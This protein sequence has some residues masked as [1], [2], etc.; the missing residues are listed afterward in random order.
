MNT[1]EHTLKVKDD[2][3]PMQFALYNI[4]IKNPEFEFRKES[5]E[6]LITSELSKVGLFGYFAQVI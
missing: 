2:L 4:H 6:N 3:A 5:V 1:A